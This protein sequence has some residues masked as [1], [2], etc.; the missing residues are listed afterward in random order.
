MPHKADSTKRINRKV[1]LLRKSSTIDFRLSFASYAE[2]LGFVKK[3][4]R[5]RDA[6]TFSELNGFWLAQSLYAMNNLEPCLL[7][8][9]RFIN[10]V[11]PHGLENQ[12]WSLFGIALSMDAPYL[13]EIRDSVLAWNA[14]TAP[15]KRDRLPVFYTDLAARSPVGNGNSVLMFTGSPSSLRNHLSSGLGNRFAALDPSDSIK[16]GMLQRSF[17]SNAPDQEISRAFKY[18]QL[19]TESA[20]A[21]GSITKDCQEN[22]AILENVWTHVTKKTWGLLGGGLGYIIG[23]KEGAFFGLESAETL[24]TWG[25]SYVTEKTS[26]AETI[27]CGLSFDNED[28]NTDVDGVG[29][30]IFGPGWDDDF[31]NGNDDT[32]T[33][34]ANTDGGG[35][36]DG[37]TDDANTDGGSADDGSTDDGIGELDFSE[38]EGW[39][40]GETDSSTDATYPVPHE[41]LST[42]PKPGITRESLY[43]MSLLRAIT[44]FGQPAP[45]ANSNHVRVTI[46]IDILTFKQN[47]VTN[48]KPDSATNNTITGKDPSSVDD[49]ITAL[50]NPGSDPD[51]SNGPSGNGGFPGGNPKP[52]LS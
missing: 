2:F 14:V 39:E 40:I 18:T 17:L 25:T 29:D 22:A 33:D 49:P 35:D 1:T 19:A 6:K 42:K 23:G 31:Y 44:K 50:I 47:Q 24:A 45:E 15:V 41:G 4:W 30:P 43:F 32:S 46:P 3:A 12:F 38:W 10:K 21:V 16:V 28:S 52:G 36:G 7:K 9:V 26:L 20:D 5:E 51:N 8:T 34:D 13:P 37:N 48:P 27:M 11:G